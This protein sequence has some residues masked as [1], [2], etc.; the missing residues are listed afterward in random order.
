MEN[1]QKNLRRRLDYQPPNYLIKDV[2]LFFDL[3]ESSTK[4]LS[5]WKFQQLKKSELFLNG[6]NLKLISLK[7][8]NSAVPTENFEQSDESLKIFN[9]PQ[10]G[11]IEILVEINPIEN[12]SLEGLY[13][14]GG[15]FCTQ[16]EAESFRKITYFLDRPDVM[17]N[18]TVTIEAHK[19][20]YPVLLSNGDRISA[21]D[22]PNNR[23][24]VVYKDPH[25]KP[26]YL[27]ALFAGNLGLLKDTFTTRSGR[28]IN[29]EIYSPH[30]TQKRCEHAMSSL[31]K[32]MKWDEERYGLEYDLDQ[33]MIVAIDDFNAGAMENKGLN[34]FNSRLILAD[35]DTATDEDFYN[36]ESVVGHEYFHNWTGNRVT[37]RDWFE[38][39]LKEGL[40]VFRDQE[41]SGDMTDRQLQ[42]IHDVNSLRD[43]QFP[44]DAGPKAHPVRPESCLSVDNFFTPTIY[45]KG[46]EVIRMMQTIVGRPGF[47][48]GMDEYFRKY[49]GNA[50]TIDDFANA[51]ALPNN[52]NL[53]QFRL[54]YSQYGTPKV[55]VLENYNSSTK[56]YTLSIKQSLETVIPQKNLKPLLIPL[57]MALLDNQGQELELTHP[58][59]TTNTEK[60]TYFALKDWE[61]A[62]EFSNMNEKPRLSI[63]REFSAPVNLIWNPPADDLYFLIENDSD[64]F[65]RREL[66]QRVEIDLLVEWIQRISQGKELEKSDCPSSFITCFKKIL[67]D[68]K[69]NLE[70]KSLMLSLPTPNRLLQIVEEFNPLFMEKS[71]NFMV[72][73]LVDELEQDF[74]RNYEIACKHADNSASR[75]LKNRMLTY[76]SRCK[77]KRH[78]EL[79]KNQYWNAKVMTERFHALFLLCEGESP[80]ADK[81]LLDFKTRYKNDSLV[82]NKWLQAQSASRAKGTF[83]R[84]KELAI[85][86][87]FNLRNPNNVYSL[88]RAFGANVL[89]FHS[90]EDDTYEFM[91][92]NIFEIDSFNPQV[93]ARLFECFQSVKKWPPQQQE[94]LK[95]YLK[96]KIALRKPSKNISEWIDSILL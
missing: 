76:L 58:R 67:N 62:L 75:S 45:E 70:L 40:T 54:W 93:A 92:D 87:E 83:N 63:L 12:A 50:V 96:N 77:D 48:K 24:Q 36:I 60:H 69:M 86:P 2:E 29:L 82:M 42:R 46:S 39:S 33:Y 61:E 14:S 22:L 80:E 65:N 11:S 53:D 19:E 5:R 37:L 26:C 72:N 4:V 18:Y 95:S 89:R 94:R 35:P 88:I 38:L 57:K 3:S 8:N 56:K 81:A 64:S 28:K 47:R 59:I 91:L 13:M 16:C 49:D 30:G 6:I 51:I 1:S 68:N 7:I 15:V 43:R 74:I 23:H 10:E 34:I 25:K 79:V 52:I 55:E 17:S 21:K 73:T 27:F 90:W 9:L 20:K 66:L 32:A 31:K 41:F 78:I 71:L 84:V 44:E 85:S